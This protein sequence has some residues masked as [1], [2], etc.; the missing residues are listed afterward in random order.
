MGRTY[1][2]TSTEVRT[3]L[4]RRPLRTAQHAL[5]VI[6]QQGLEDLVPDLAHHLA[7]DMTWWE[8]ATVRGWISSNL[9]GVPPLRHVQEQC[10]GSMMNHPRSHR[11]TFV[12]CLISGS[13]SPSMIY[14]IMEVMIWMRWSLT[15]PSR[16]H[17]GLHA[18]VAR[19]K[20][21]VHACGHG[22]VPIRTSPDDCNTEALALPL[23]ANHIPIVMP[24][25]WAPK[26]WT[27]TPSPLS[28]A[29]FNP[30]DPPAEKCGLVSNK[31]CWFRA[32]HT[33]VCTRTA[34]S[35]AGPDLEIV[36]FTSMPTLHVPYADD[37]V[38]YH[39]AGRKNMA[40][41]QLL[42]GMAS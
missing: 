4:Q 26:D 13:P 22:V 19:L 30:N 5:Y 7:Q 14:A 15:Y 32:F 27:R 9:H 8:E 1:D 18:E 31:R 10:S 23:V 3:F 29:F 28:W 21:S 38:T 34:T 37:F 33:N 39:L 12:D 42:H 40:I 11:S 35:A 41:S 17:A 16:A 36:M 6:K 20:R 2:V 25:T 24:S